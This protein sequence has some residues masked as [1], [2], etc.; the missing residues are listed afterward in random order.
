MSREILQLMFDAM[1]GEKRKEGKR[2][3]NLYR[4]IE[5]VMKEIAV[6]L[7][8]ANYENIRPKIIK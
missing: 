3:K 7:L 8:F 6:Q 1:N 5:P 4:M 2:E